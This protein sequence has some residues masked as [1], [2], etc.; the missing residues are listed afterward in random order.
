MSAGVGSPERIGI[1]ALWYRCARDKGGAAMYRQR[2]A[3]FYPAQVSQGDMAEAQV[4]PDG[5]LP[6]SFRDLSGGAG[7]AVTPL[8]GDSDR[9]DRT[10]DLEGE[11]VDATLTPEGPV[12]LSARLRTLP[13]P[14]AEP[15]DHLVGSLWKNRNQPAYFAMGRYVYAFNGATWGLVGDLG[16]GLSATGDMAHFRGTSAADT[17]YCPVGYG[18]PLRYSADQGVTWAAVDPSGDVTNVQ[19]LVELDGEIVMA[20][21]SPRAGDAMIGV[22]DNGTGVPTLFNVIDPIGDSDTPISRLIAFNGRLLVIK[23]SEGVFLLDEQRRTLEQDL[24]PELRGQRIYYLGITV[25]RGLLWLPTDTALYA[26][27]PGLSLQ[28]VGPEQTETGY[29]AP[30]APRGPI[31]ALAGD[32]HNLYAF[33][34]SRTGPGWVYKANVAVSSGGVEEVAWHPWQCQAVSHCRAMRVVSP[35][36]DGPRLVW[37]RM[38]PVGTGTP[39]VPADRFTV[40]WCKLPRKG[41]DPRLDA[42][43]P[44][45]PGGTL[46][47]SRLIA[48]FPGIDKSFYGITPLCA[49]LD[50]KVDGQT[51]TSAQAI[52]VL[53]K[54]DVQPVDATATHGYYLGRVQTA[55]TGTREPFVLFGRGLD[56]GIRLSS[57]DE[58]TTPQVY[59]VTIDYNLNP[60]VVWRH[61]MTLDLSSGAYAGSGLDGFG[62]PLTPVNALI[63]LR[64]LPGVPGNIALTDLWG[65]PYDVSIPIDGVALRSANPEEVGYSGEI[66]LLVDVVAVEQASRLTGTWGKVALMTWQQVSQYLWGQLPTLG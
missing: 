45:A 55:G 48:R 54:L 47:Y 46:Y 13:M 25:W 15:A 10:G 51:T 22:F 44:Y 5:R 21:R 32:A 42:E 31:T 14:G 59:S 3:P 39:P 40:G 23:D 58:T 37:G 6:F 41:R 66:P 30:E 57:S 2:P 17:W 9:Y 35:N 26:I 1:G 56:T 60:L 36:N 24:F 62:D 52:R 50:L 49:P 20:M 11:G 28:A 63:L 53:Y 7:L 29:I 43:Y 19:S 27:T 65:Q 33:R 64:Q 16:A 38:L 34:E 4:S 18:A 61:E 12:I 8:Q